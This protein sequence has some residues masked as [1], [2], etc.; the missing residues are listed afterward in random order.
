MGVTTRFRRK[1]KKVKER[2]ARRVRAEQRAADELDELIEYGRAALTAPGSAPLAMQLDTALRVAG[3]HLRRAERSGNVDDVHWA[4]TLASFVA[5]RCQD[6]PPASVIEL[7]ARAVAVLDLCVAHVP[8]TEATAIQELTERTRDRLDRA[9]QLC[10]LSLDD[11]I[12]S[13]VIAKTLLAHAPTTEDR[14]VVLDRARALLATT[15]IAARRAGNEQ[16][17]EAAV[18]LIESATEK[19]P[20]EELKGRRGLRRSR[21]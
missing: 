8:E 12:S 5:D 18:T 13:L 4:V 3:L 16:L 19:K 14:G 10:A 21:A 2:P 17:A 1:D 20:A 6:T 9:E 7:A 15:A 11:A